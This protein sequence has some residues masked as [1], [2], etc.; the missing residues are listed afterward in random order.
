MLGCSSDHSLRGYTCSDGCKREVNL[1]GSGT[2][3]VCVRCCT[4]NKCNGVGGE[5]PKNST[6]TVQLKDK[7]DNPVQLN[8]VHPLKRNVNLTIIFS[9]IFLAFSNGY[10]YNP[11]YHGN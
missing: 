11:K 10:I 7:V 2:S 9:M 5:T 1:V 4:G 8:G 3:T 6:Q